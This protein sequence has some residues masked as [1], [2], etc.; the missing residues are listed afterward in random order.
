MRHIQHWAIDY[1]YLIKG[2]WLSYSYKNSPAHYLGQV[3]EN[4][5]PIIL[6]P[7]L[8]EKW[9]FMKKIGDAL[10]K[11]GHPVYIVPALGRNLKDIP[12]SAQIVYQLIEQE[13]LKKVILVAHSKGGLIGKYL[14]TNLDKNQQIEKLIAIATPWSG[15]HLAK[16][17]PGKNHHELKPDNPLIKDLAGQSSVNK[18]IISIYPEFDNH[19][20][21]KNGSYLDGA[22]N[23]QLKIKGHH[24][25]LFDKDILK[26]IQTFVNQS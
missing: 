21:H 7:G 10:S 23:V 6:I 24:K 9:Q 3:S 14:M 17:L 2:Q 11:D 12:Q 18:K 8:G 19:V 5:P 25:I 22:K 1:I 4:K 15:S 13:K 20:W 16:I 26:T